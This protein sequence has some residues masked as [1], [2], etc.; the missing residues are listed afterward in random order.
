MDE[1]RWTTNKWT[2][3]V[4]KRF[5]WM[6]F[7]GTDE[8]GFLELVYFHQQVYNKCAYWRKYAKNTR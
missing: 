3:D 4:G 5:G 8:L 2:R 7:F 1:G 6:D